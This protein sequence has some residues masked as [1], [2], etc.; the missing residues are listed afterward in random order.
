MRLT[1]ITATAGLLLALT[2]T[3]CSSTPPASPPPATTTAAATTPA[4]TA[5]DRQACVEAIADV[6]DQRPDDFDPETDSDP[7]PLECA[8]I[9]EAE[10]LDVY[11]E[12]LRLRNER[13][14]DELQRQIDEAASADA[15][16]P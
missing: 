4:A 11:M 1:P 5:A 16:T 2:L 6:I 15:A 3:A 9:P 8:G 10:S 14:R 13:S 7:E 12:G